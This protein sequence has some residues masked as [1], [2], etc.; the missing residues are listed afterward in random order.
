M[1]FS[2]INSIVFF[3]V[4][5]GVL[6]SFH[7]YGHFWV[8]RRLGV[9]V[10]RFSI[11]FGPP[12]L[13]FKSAKRETEYVI[14]AIPLGG[15]VRMLD[16]SQDEVS[17]DQLPYA[18][19]RQPLYVR[20]AIVA[21]GPIFNFILAALLFGA[22]F[23]IGVEGSRPYVGEVVPGSIGER[24]G[25]EI[26]DEINYVDGR[27]NQSWEQ[28]RY[29]ILDKI[30]DGESVTFEALNRGAQA[31]TITVDFSEIDGLEVQ[32]RSVEQILGVYPSTA[33][34]LPII[35]EV[36][37]DTPAAAA[38]LMAKD[39]ILEVNGSEVYSWTRLVSQII[40]SPG[41]QVALLVQRGTEVFETTVV[42]EPVDIDGQVIGRIGVKVD[43]EQQERVANDQIVVRYG[44]FESMV[45][46]VQS[47]W[48]MTTLTLKMLAKMFDYDQ[49]A[50]S[51]G[52]P[53]TIAVYAGQAAESGLNTYLSFLALLSIS[54]GI[55]N[56]LPIPILDG[57]HLLFHL[58][59]AVTGKR[60]TEQM[61]QW[62]T[63]I[64]I[65]IIISIMVLAFYNDV[66]LLL[67]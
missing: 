21:A 60:P 14:S 49:P 1:D 4:A 59:E 16:E 63:R 10:L 33:V 53:V 66:I 35:G 56:L 29:Y 62:G 40:E 51:L 15:Y 43:L 7:E 31:K 26:G 36:V 22:T 64:G 54:L 34:L 17:E 44:T 50:N 6:I 45:R 55:L 20:S 48:L 46:G 47:M 12:L 37:T 18:F 52:G 30:V 38:Q 61:I 28:H 13:R 23:L 19:N 3:I 65:A 58:Y 57:G 39:L 9:S 8:A 41:A 27:I 25:F 2:F 42:P 5:V 24:S 67:N 11:G 32:Q